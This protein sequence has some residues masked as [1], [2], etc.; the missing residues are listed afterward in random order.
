MKKE[1]EL[2]TEAATDELV[3]EKRRSLLKKGRRKSK[4]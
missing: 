4:E 1:S 3:T 2:N